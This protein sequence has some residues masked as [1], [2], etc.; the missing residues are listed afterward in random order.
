MKKPD[1]NNNPKA[2][3]AAA[4]KGRKPPQ[5]DPI[6][7]LRS[8]PQ[9][10]SSPDIEAENRA[11]R[12]LLHT[13]TRDAAYNQTVMQRFQERELALL[14]AN[15]LPD[16]LERLTA[17]LRA[18]FALDEVTL[19]LFDPYRVLRDLLGALGSAPEDMQD[20]SISEDFRGSLANY[21]NPEQVSLGTWNANAHRALFKHSYHRSVAI[22]PLRQRD[23]IAG[24]LHLGSRKPDRFNATQGTVFLER[25]AHIAAICLENAVNRE[26]LRLTGLTD[27]LTGLYNRRHL[28]QRLNE[29]VARALRHGHPL[30]CLFID[31]DHFK[32]INDRHG[33]AA[34]D[35]VL[36]ALAQR[37]RTEL[38][39]S[40]LPARYGGEEIAVLLPQTDLANARKL[41]ERI[42][43]AIADTPVATQNNIDIAVSVSIG[44][45]QLHS[46]GQGSIEEQATQLL[47]AA[48]HEV[49]RAKQSGRNRVCCAEP[50]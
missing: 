36:V 49:Y 17:G 20:L 31:A 22:L 39:S 23:S 34:G 33:H 38:R 46:E 13:L 42:R 4:D 2:F 7:M 9:M 24:F 43:S 37:I 8:C 19:L 11:L 32:K 25:L 41:A 48:D 28:D 18:S 30:S 35:Q 14:T 26:R 6:P 10:D 3:E 16:L 50:V 40:D 1:I 12:Q 44:L 27:G 47:E 45:A 29:E 21:K 15:D 5:D